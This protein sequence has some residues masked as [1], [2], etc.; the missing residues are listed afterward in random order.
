MCT[1]PSVISQLHLINWTS[2]VFS[3]QHSYESSE[4]ILSLFQL[5][6]LDQ[7]Q[8]HSLNRCDSREKTEK[9]N[10]GKSNR[11]GSWET[12]PY[13][14]T[15]IKH[16]RACLPIFFFFAHTVF[17]KVQLVKWGRENEAR[18]PASSS[19]LLVSIQIV[20]NEEICHETCRQCTHDEEISTCRG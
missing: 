4:S 12:N 14:N 15:T 18:H 13:N 1:G 19:N 6:T 11:T 5:Q 16:I 7:L 9:N 10:V 8:L 3:H 20:G 17:P 2:I